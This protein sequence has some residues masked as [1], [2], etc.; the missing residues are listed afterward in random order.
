MRAPPSSRHVAEGARLSYGTAVA[1]EPGLSARAF[2]VVG[3]SDTALAMKSGDVP[4]LA[5]PRLVALCEE[6]ACQ[7]VEG[8]LGGG[9]TSVG[10]RIQFDHLAPVCT[11]VEV[12]AEAV[13]EKVEGRRLVFTVTATDSAGLI[14][15]GKVT[16]VVVNRQEFLARA[17]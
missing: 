10:V 13:L 7:A 8:T 17:R 5:T 6:A 2:M 12:A 14:G 1:I 11:G 15:A 3:E 4:V 9:R 16:R